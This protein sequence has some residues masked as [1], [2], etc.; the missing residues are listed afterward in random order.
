MKIGLISLITPNMNAPLNQK[1]WRI[2]DYSKIARERTDVICSIV[3]GHPE[4]DLIVFSG[5]TLEKKGLPAFLANN[6]NLNSMVILEW[7]SYWA[8]IQGKNIIK[9]DI[10]QLFAKS[11]QA[12][13]E[14]VEKLLNR[15]EGERIVRVKKNI[16][17]LVIC[18]KNNMLINRQSEGNRV[19]FRFPGQKDKFERLCENTD[20]F[21]N[22]AYTPM[23]NLGKMRKRWSYLNQNERLCVFTTNALEK[24]GLK[25]NRLQYVFINGKRQ[26]TD[27]TI[28]DDYRITIF[29][30]GR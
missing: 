17:R 29:E 28:M 14:M 9:E 1:K 11:S 22:P 30:W 7:D 5:N 15:L 21:L 4:L 13:P 24:K 20:A 16:C 26:N 12:K 27:T 18:G 6:R 10:E 23:G 19:Y 3:N 25:Q 2:S 8:F